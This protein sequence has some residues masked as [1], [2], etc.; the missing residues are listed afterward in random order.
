[1][2]LIIVLSAFMLMQSCKIDKKQGQPNTVGVEKENTV[3]IISEKMDFQ[4]PDTISSGWNTFLYKNQS[5]QTHFFLFEKYPEGKTLADAK[6]QVIPY[7]SSGLK[8][9]NEGNLEKAMAEFGKLPKWYGNVE[10][11]GG[12]GLVSA[13]KT[14]VTAVKLEPGYYLV[15]CYVKMSNGVFHTSMGMIDE[16]VVS[17]HKSGNKE[18]NPDFTIEISSQDG[19]VFKDSIPSGKHTFLVTFKDQIVH[20]NFVGHDINLVRFNENV[21]LEKL[22]SWMN[23]V[24]PKGL[25]DPLPKEFTFMGGVNDMPA[26]SRGYFIASLEPG[27]Y[28]LVSEVPNTL[29]KNMLRTFVVS[30]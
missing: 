19:I 13:D 21:N 27:Q 5:P 2:L 30:K 23:W 10:F 4:M 8:Q 12:S 28:A 20:E 7:F 17:D 26:G 11:S 29:S 3:E 9:I 16:F 1:M 24:N 25:I 6:S 15:E 18:L 22:E 14:S